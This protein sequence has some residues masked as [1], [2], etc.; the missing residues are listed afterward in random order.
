MCIGA[1]E[2]QARCCDPKG[3]GTTF[4]L[5]PLQHHYFY[6]YVP[7]HTEVEIVMLEQTKNKV[8]S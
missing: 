8:S 1:K 2:N 5:V 7:S 4:I 3:S 6:S